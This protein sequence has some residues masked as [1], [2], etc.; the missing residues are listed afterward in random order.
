MLHCAAQQRRCLRTVKRFNFGLGS[1]NPHPTQCRIATGTVQK[2]VGRLISIPM[3]HRTENVADARCSKCLQPLDAYHAEQA[4]SETGT[5]LA[6][7]QPSKTAPDNS[8][9]EC[10]AANCDHNSTAGVKLCTSQ[11]G[12]RVQCSM[13]EGA[14]WMPGNTSWEKGKLSVVNWMIPVGINLY[15]LQPF[16]SWL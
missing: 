1:V 5:A 6:Q 9:R 3:K 7:H 12:D 11:P 4:V 8:T 15:K 10:T 16:G 13:H 2:S 14:S